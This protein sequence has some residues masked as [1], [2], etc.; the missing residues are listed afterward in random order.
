MMGEARESTANP[1]F[2]ETFQRALKEMTEKIWLREWQPPPPFDDEVDPGTPYIVEDMHEQGAE[3]RLH[4]QSLMPLVGAS[5]QE[6][7]HM[8]LTGRRPGVDEVAIAKRIVHKSIRVVEGDLSKK[9]E[10]PEEPPLMEELAGAAKIAPAENWRSACYLAGGAMMDVLAFGNVRPTRAQQKILYGAAL[11][12][13]SDLTERAISEAFGVSE[14][15]LRV[16]ARLLDRY[17]YAVM[18]VDQGPEMERVRDRISRYLVAEG[19]MSYKAYQ[20]KR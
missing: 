14:K 15:T 17:D 16:W 8:K 20:G 2:Y 1:Q 11:L 10:P 3:D 18:T 12:V 19:F 5:R 6:R 7:L 13:H 4:E 9:T